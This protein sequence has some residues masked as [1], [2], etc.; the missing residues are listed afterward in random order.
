MKIYTVWGTRKHAPDDPELMTAWDEFSVDNNPEGYREDIKD[1][2]EGWGSDYHTHREIAVILP[3]AA[4]LAAFE[5]PE[6]HG[7]VE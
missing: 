6:I 5:T 1:Q 3:Y 7:G 2:I 4:V